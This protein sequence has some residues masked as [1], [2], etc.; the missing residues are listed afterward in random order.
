[1]SDRGAGRLSR[2]AAVAPVLPPYAYPQEQIAAGFADLVLPAGQDP[3]VLLRL[4]AASGVRRRHLA[5]PL[6]EY[7]GLD[8][9]GSANDV[10]I[11]VGADLAERAVQQALDSAGLAAG[12]VDLVLAT[13]VTGIAAPSLEA[14]L[15]PRLGL[16]RDVKRLPTFGLGCVAG[17][18]GLARVHDYLRGD[19]DGVAVLLSV[20]L[21]SLTLQRDD[22]SSAN[23]VASGLFG[24]GAAA[25]VMVGER[26]ARDLGIDGPDVVATRSLLYPDTESLL[27]WSIGGGGFRIVLSANISDLVERS[28]GEDVRDFLEEH[29]L[30]PVDLA[31]WVVHPGGPKVL[32]ATALALDLDDDALALSRASLADRGNLSSASVLHIL[33]DTLDGPSPMPGEHAL[34]IAMGPGFS[35]ELVLVRW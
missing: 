23:L 12:D 15:V 33:A 19:P 22:T 24:D 8:G 26:R 11:R 6:E 5:M 18:A 10:F 28:L 21:C 20:E 35:V 7:A 17:A 25:V 3:R 30:K 34:V 2:I 4:H 32:D 16:R 31:R 27:G 1:M 9:F 29:E 13:S 14:M